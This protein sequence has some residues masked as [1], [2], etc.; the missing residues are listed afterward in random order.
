MSGR[1]GIASQNDLRSQILRAWNRPLV[2]V[3][4]MRTLPLTRACAGS[5][6]LLVPSSNIII[7]FRGSA[8]IHKGRARTGG[9]GVGVAEARTLDRHAHET[10]KHFFPLVRVVFA[11]GGG[12]RVRR[13]P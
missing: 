11:R 9:I 7:I 12:R 2:H 13:R 8:S 6:L 10:S 3:A 1:S 4:R 5:P